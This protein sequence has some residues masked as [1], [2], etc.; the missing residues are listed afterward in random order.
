MPRFRFN[1]ANLSEQLLGALGKELALTG[2]PSNELRRIYGARPKEE[3]IADNWQILQR[4]WLNSDDVSRSSIAATLRER[5]VGQPEV[6]NDAD[7]LATCRNTAGLRRVVLPVFITLGEQP[8]DAMGT[9]PVGD[10]NDGAGPFGGR[11]RLG[12][13]STNVS[14]GD[15]GSPGSASVADRP[16]SLDGANQVERL[17][18]WV[19]DVLRVMFD[20]PEIQSD[21]D[22]DFALPQYGSSR[23]YLSV[24]EKP[25]RLEIF[26]V[27]LDEVEY[28]EQLM[29]TLNLIN[30]R[31]VYE[32]IRY[33]PDQKIAVMSSHLDA[34]G[35]SANSLGTY[36]RM[37]A[38]AA[39]HFDTHLE[40]QFGGQKAGDDRRSDEQ[41]V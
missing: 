24:L 3:F 35:L 38:M 27:L 19:G 14:D 26:S 12:G 10:A 2:D 20:N 30:G 36:I 40:E 18:D 32:K 7:Y 25:L 6:T 34:S 28:S 41:I 9:A 29:K 13:D 22:G 31:L 15:T 17:R 21:D 4:V 23:L 1:W 39:D 8:R 33:V 5:A 16:S 11:N 37:A